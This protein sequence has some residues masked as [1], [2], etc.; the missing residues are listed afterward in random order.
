MTTSTRR[1]HA[2]AWVLAFLAAALAVV[3]GLFTAG[4]AS[5]ATHSTAQNAVGASST[6]AQV[7]VEPSASI[8]AGQ[9]LGKD[10]P[11]LRIVVATG[12]APKTADHVLPI[13]S[14]PQKAWSVLNRIDAKG[15]PLPGYKGGSV[16]KNSQGRLPETPGVTYRE[17][18]VNPYAKGV[19]RGPERIVTGSDG[20]AYWT[21]DHYNTF[22]MFRGATQ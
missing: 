15:A 18:D 16:F 2:P 13:G 22:V 11:R 6:A 19:K 5:A 21:G 20:S 17:W 7:A 3:L 8:T 9:R 1:A 4:P 12:V 14:G 10:P